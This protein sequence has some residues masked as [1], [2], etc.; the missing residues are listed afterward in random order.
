MAPV[1]AGTPPFSVLCPW[2]VVPCPQIGGAGLDT[3]MAAM[4][5]KEP[6][7]ACR[8]HFE[9]RHPGAVVEA[10]GNHPNT[11]FSESQAYIKA[12]NAKAGAG[13]AAAAAAAAGGGGGG[14]SA[15]AG[16]AGAGGA[17][18]DASVVLTPPGSRRIDDGTA[19]AAAAAVPSE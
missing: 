6:Q 4:K 16:A 5:N 19:A 13:S 8:R 18:D 9:V 12:K 7:V 14:V 15:G 17:T 2:L 11:Y 1:A 10:V 3:I